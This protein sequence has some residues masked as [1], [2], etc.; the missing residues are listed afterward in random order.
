MHPVLP[1]S[2]EALNTYRGMNQTRKK[3]PILI[4]VLNTNRGAL[5]HVALD[6]PATKNTSPWGALAT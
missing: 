1:P 4:K 3:Y 5:A 6:L 2:S